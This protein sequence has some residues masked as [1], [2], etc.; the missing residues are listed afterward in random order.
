MSGGRERVAIMHMDE[1][2]K[3]DL[4]AYAICAACI[5]EADLQDYI[6]ETDGEPGCSF[7]EQSDAPTCNFKDLMDHVQSCLEGEYD[8]AANWLPYESAE[9]GWLSDRYW[10]TPDLITDQLGIGLPRNDHGVLLLAMV[11]GLGGL[12]DGSHRRRLIGVD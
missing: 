4:R 10:D 2:R 7:C 12:D 5:E 3:S 9:G 6:R 8:T 1:Y 11:D